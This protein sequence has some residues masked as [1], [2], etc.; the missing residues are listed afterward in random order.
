MQIDHI[1]L[2]GTDNQW[3]NLRLVTQSDNMRNQKLISRNTSGVCGVSQDRKSGRWTANIYIAPKNKNLGS[4]VD[5][6]DA[7]CARKSAEITYGYGPNH[8]KRLEMPT[9]FKRQIKE[10]EARLGIT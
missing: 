6:F 1:N 9:Q 7:V 8:G 2:V 3:E 10:Q 5:W 4:F